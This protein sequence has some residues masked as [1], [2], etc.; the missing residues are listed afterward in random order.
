MAIESIYLELDYIYNPTQ[1]VNLISTCRGL[2]HLCLYI[3]YY[4]LR[5]KIVGWESLLR[6]RG[7]ESFA[8][9][10]IPN[11]NGY[12]EAGRA[13]SSK[14]M[15]LLVEAKGVGGR[16]HVAHVQREAMRPRTEEDGIEAEEAVANDCYCPQSLLLHRRIRLLA[17]IARIRNIFWLPERIGSTGEMGPAEIHLGG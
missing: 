12:N 8:V 17:A 16:Q 9:M 2:K 6:I 5:P 4:D 10:A 14:N 1:A 3:D 13:G 15:A 7:L 11:K